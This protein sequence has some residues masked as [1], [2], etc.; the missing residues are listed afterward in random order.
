MRMHEI[1]L[2][3]DSAIASLILVFRFVFLHNVFKFE[4]EVSQTNFLLRAGSRDTRETLTVALVNK[5][6]LSFFEYVSCLPA[7]SDS[8]TGC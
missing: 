5:Y 8:I 6:S 4:S 1:I 3:N 2:E 7:C